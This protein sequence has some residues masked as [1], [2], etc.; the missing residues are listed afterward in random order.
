MRSLN[1]EGYRKEANS[2]HF[3]HSSSKQPGLNRERN[4]KS[5]H[6]DEENKRENFRLSQTRS[7]NKSKGNIPSHKPLD[8]SSIPSKEQKEKR[9][10]GN[11]MVPKRL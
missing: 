6:F 10:L 3:F 4:K 1:E 7:K 8:F 11:V 2:N 9:K 5:V